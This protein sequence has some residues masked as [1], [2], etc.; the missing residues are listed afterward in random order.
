[1]YVLLSVEL[2]HVRNV[3]GYGSIISICTVYPF[4]LLLSD[5][6]EAPPGI[7]E[8]VVDQRR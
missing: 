6:S 5:L 8:E 7:S 3:Q 1:M 4:L 2:Q